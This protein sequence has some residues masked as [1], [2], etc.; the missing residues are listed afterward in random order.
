MLFALYL[1]LNYKWQYYGYYRRDKC[2]KDNKNILF[3]PNEILTSGACFFI[4]F[5]PYNGKCNMSM[6]YS[7]FP[8]GLI[9]IVA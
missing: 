6:L 8:F 9:D 1:L 3:L 7:D 5:N 2:H 4:F